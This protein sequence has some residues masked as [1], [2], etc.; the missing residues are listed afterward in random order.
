MKSPC[1]L[2]TVGLVALMLCSGCASLKRFG[3][4]GWGRDRWQQPDKVVDTLA[5]APGTAVA[6]IGAGG[7]YFAFRLA[8][9]V[10]PT[11]KVY[12]VDVD[13]DMTAYLEQRAAT[14]KVQH[15]E[16]VLAPT[17]APGLAEASVDLLFTCN[18]Y[19]HLDDPAA[20]FARA[21]TSL[22]PGGRVAILDF[23]GHGWFSRLFAHATPAEQ[24]RR[25]M[26]Q[27]GYDLVAQPDFL[28]QQNFLIFR[29]VEAE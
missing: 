4:E 8:E 7:G 26:E 29:V 5:L 24:I 2:W 13:P 11:G 16:V 23:N 18:T 27:A 19:H 14:E 12:A 20:Y 1:S 28:S 21:K 10:G 25:D 9:A 3:Y 6:D 22:R 17:D 15:L